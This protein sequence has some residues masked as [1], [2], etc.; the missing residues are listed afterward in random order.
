MFFMIFIDPKI[1][2]NRG[3]I[4]LTP[5]ISKAFIKSRSRLLPF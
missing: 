5:T 1:D 4:G 3:H 2:R